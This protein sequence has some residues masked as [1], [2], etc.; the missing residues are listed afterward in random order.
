MH[1]AV[2]HHTAAEIIYQRADSEQPYMGLTTWKKAPD[3]RVQKSDTIVA[4]NYLSDSELSQLN[5][6]TTAFLD[7]AESR[8]AAIRS[9]EPKSTYLTEAGKRI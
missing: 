1:L 7:M 5:L 9:S 4:K 8:A 3:G 2:T 6:I